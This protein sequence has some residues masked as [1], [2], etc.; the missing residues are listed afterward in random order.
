MQ[1]LKHC[2]INRIP[3]LMREKCLYYS[4]HYY[5]VIIPINALIG[6]DC[7]YCQTG[8][9]G[10]YAGGQGGE[11]GWLDLDEFQNARLGKCEGL[12]GTALQER[13]P[14]GRLTEWA[15]CS[16]SLVSISTGRT[17]KLFPTPT[18]CCQ[19][20]GSPVQEMQWCEGGKTGPPRYGV[21]QINGLREIS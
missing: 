21:Q 2:Q 4:L 8:G 14:V 20:G 1:K 5:Q 13:G 12:A 17:S 16:N 6:V 19:F 18:I 3:Q 11:I 15:G 7:T 9:R 10:W